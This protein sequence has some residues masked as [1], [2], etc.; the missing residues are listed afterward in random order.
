[1]A[2][3]QAHP[4][5]GPKKL[6]AWLKDREPCPDANRGWS[7][8]STVGDLLN[9]AGQVRRR[10]RRRQTA[11]WSQPFVQ[12]EQPNDLWCIDFKGWF[13]REMGR[14]VDPLTVEDASSRYLLACHGLRQTRGSEVRRVLER[15]FREYGLPQAIRTD[16]GSPFASA[17][18]GG[19][20]S[21]V[22]W[23]VKL[24]ILP[25]RIEPG[26]PE[27]NGRLERLH[28]TLKAETASPPQPALAEAAACLPRLSFQLQPRAA[29]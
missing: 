6:V 5:W 10:K 11:P 14:G 18:L 19:L 23:W 12:A 3:R 22:V 27:Q 16:N 8:P 7:A 9:R 26:H 15:A 20:S 24:G 25:E 2:A 21:L 17:G 1:M 13:P 28:R 29:P 4:T